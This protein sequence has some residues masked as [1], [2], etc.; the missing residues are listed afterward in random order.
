MA[1]H[2]PTKM[3]YNRNNLPPKAPSTSPSASGRSLGEHLS[4]TRPRATNNKARSTSN[5]SGT[6]QHTAATNNTAASDAS[7]QGL[8]SAVLKRRQS[9]T[10]SEYTFLQGIVANGTEVEVS[11][12]A[13][14]LNDP[15]LF[16]DIDDNDKE[17]GN[18]SHDSSA[19]EKSSKEDNNTISSASV[20]DM[21]GSI[22]TCASYA[23]WSNNPNNKAPY[24]PIPVSPRQYQA[25]MTI[26]S[27]DELYPE[28]SHGNDDSGDF[29][30]SNNHNPGMMMPT[31]MVS[32][33]EQTPLAQNLTIVGNGKSLDGALSVP[34]F[35]PED[36]MDVLINDI[37]RTSLSAAPIN[38][39]PNAAA[40][41][42]VVLERRTSTP[43]V[44][45]LWRAHEQGLAVTPGQS[46]RRL[47]RRE[48]SLSASPNI[49]RYSAA[50]AG[51][52]NATNTIRNVTLG[53]ASAGVRSNSNND[54][55]S[56]LNPQELRRVKQRDVRTQS[57]TRAMLLRHASTDDDGSITGN[58]NNGDLTTLLLPTDEDIFRRA[59]E[60]QRQ[61][62]FANSNHANTGTIKRTD[63]PDRPPPPRPFGKANTNSS[64]DAPNTASAS[65]STSPPPP[66][67]PMMSTLRRRA[68]DG[69]TAPPTLQ[70]RPS[71]LLRRM[72]SDGYVAVR[73]KSVTFQMSSES[74]DTGDDSLSTYGSEYPNHNH[75]NNNMT[76]VIRTGGGR[77]RE[78]SGLTV[79]NSTS[80]ECGTDSVT[81]TSPPTDGTAS[82]N[83]HRAYPVRQDSIASTAEG[84]EAARAFQDNLNENDNNDG[85]S[86]PSLAW[87]ESTASGASL[88]LHHAHPINQES[89]VFVD[90]SFWGREDSSSAPSL[91]L[92]RARPVLRQESIASTAE[93]LDAARAFQDDLGYDVLDASSPS[94]A[95]AASVVSRN[96]HRAHPVRQDSIAST[97]GGEQALQAFQRQ[98]DAG[99]DFY[100]ASN[101]NN[102][103]D[104]A[105]SLASLNLDMATPIKES[106]FKR[107]ESMASVALG[108]ADLDAEEAFR[109]AGW[110]RRESMNSLASL[111]LH[112][113]HPL[114][115][116][117]SVAA[118]VAERWVRQESLH[119]HK[120]A[121][122]RRDSMAST[123]GGLDAMEAFRE[124]V[125]METWGRRDSM[126]SIASLSLRHARPLRQA[127]MASNAA[128]LEASETI[129]E[130]FA[131]APNT[132]IRTSKPSW[133][134]QDSTDSV[135]SLNLYQAHPVASESV[136]IDILRN[137]GSAFS[138]EDFERN[139]MSLPPP[140]DAQIMSSMN[141]IP[142]LRPAFPLRQE[143]IV[144]CADGR[145]AREKLCSD[146][147]QAALI[148]SEWEGVVSP[149][150]E[151]KKSD[152]DVVQPILK[153]TGRDVPRPVFMRR[154]SASEY[155]GEGMEVAPLEEGPSPALKLKMQIVVPARDEVAP[156]A[157]SPLAV[158]TTKEEDQPAAASETKQQS[159]NIYRQVSNSMARKQY[160]L[161][162]NASFDESKSVQRLQG[163]FRGEIPRSISEDELTTLFSPYCKPAPL[164]REQSNA[165]VY[166]KDLNSE[167]WE[168]DTVAGD[169][170]AW[171][172][173]N[174]EYQNGYGGG[175]TL[176]FRI[177]GTNANDL[178]SQPH[179]L[180]PPLMESLQSFLP[181]TK[182]HD[183]FWMKYSMVRDGSSL[184]SLMQHARGAKYSILALETTD[185]EVFGAFTTEPWRKTWSYF[186]GGES[187][188]WKMRSSR[189]TK[190][191]SIID[192]AKMESE[193]DVYPC[194]GANPCIQLCTHN[195]IAVGGGSPEH[196][197]DEEK[198][199]DNEN[200]HVSVNLDETDE[201]KEHEWGYG[202]ALQSDLLHGSSSPC[203]TFGSPSLSNTHSDGSLFEILN[204]E[205]WSLTPCS[206]VRE[207]ENLE[208]GKM[209]LEQSSFRNDSFE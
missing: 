23:S 205:L 41:R 166:P 72:P 51:N 10:T 194:T 40:L 77:Q 115:H 38:K 50:G 56:L 39:P 123:A 132:V 201:I 116:Q 112:H 187:F 133:R 84:W 74:N 198:R 204:I 131:V 142:S 104:Q 164:A 190:C 66:G 59:I 95:A 28:S 9:L 6:S 7:R 52:T 170:D 105:Y 179:V 16:F 122:L 71:I 195:K 15:S 85:L 103:D 135:G 151:D 174:D 29:N 109:P 48:Q 99:S 168:M 152:D 11:L 22:D 113:A 53:G 73:S 36:T 163:V 54:V 153:V 126:S 127:S 192:Q 129:R 91:N 18:T 167:S 107:Q 61:A 89:P 124:R 5:A 144:S 63:G 81:C 114:R 191:F 80:W 173:I 209:F 43:L 26:P 146:F 32:D 161:E 165:K 139:S 34:I 94:S 101:T 4:L 154:A 145:E 79:T 44:G 30:S 97:Y 67:P 176:P 69:L 181:N 119:L 159:Q 207:A 121:P 143:S 31:L 208:L 106:I 199:D 162:M 200:R 185:G 24:T 13:K 178:D 155:D 65:S 46:H 160:N 171:T 78:V 206:N 27:M 8:R 14:K 189:K 120:A 42:P 33:L 140:G 21:E 45:Q 118:S 92:H 3:M 188:L 130:E 183:N 68:S 193:I 83:L 141:S 108:G 57:H 110:S 76:D 62:A 128:G 37:A 87:R 182:S 12:V 125:A 177:L 60:M 137:Q 2:T 70:R 186:G 100:F 17:I 47:S 64:V 150:E 20:M 156:P 88:N 172:A 197:E 136:I 75:N 138:T 148:A 55:R 35:G 175:N 49:R 111:D 184:H 86:K 158:P 102:D 180:S 117:D 134:R 169:Y 93:G 202:L 196:T 98:F 149:D 82:L 203:L 19:E 157:I 96:L 90:K 147:G 25:T 1:T 58:S